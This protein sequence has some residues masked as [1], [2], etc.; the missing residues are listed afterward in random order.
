MALFVVLLAVLK[1]HAHTIVA[2]AVAP[3]R[4][5]ASRRRTIFV[6]SNHRGTPRI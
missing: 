3:L 1:L 6:D 5:R 4:C 2:V